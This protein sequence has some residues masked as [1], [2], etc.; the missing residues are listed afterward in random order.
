MPAL[1]EAPR[2]L[3]EGGELN[4]LVELRLRAMSSRDEIVEQHPSGAKVR[5]MLSRDP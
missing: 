4:E 2:C 3:P 5:P 1:Q